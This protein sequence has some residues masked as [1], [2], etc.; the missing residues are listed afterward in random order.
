MVLHRVSGVKCSVSKVEGVRGRGAGNSRTSRK[1][2][3]LHE[4]VDRVVPGAL[5][6]LLLDLLVDEVVGV[7]DRVRGA[8]DGDDAVARARRERALLAD[9]DVGAGHL[10]DLDEAASARTCVTHTHTCTHV[11][12]SYCP[13][14]V[15]NSL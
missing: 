14:Q 10:L 6:L 12:I 13:H 5:Q 7:G 11:T 1:V 15:V 8:R 2:Q 9:L 3:L 4:R